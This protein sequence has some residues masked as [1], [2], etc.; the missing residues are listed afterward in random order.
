MKDLKNL[1]KYIKERNIRN[2]ANNTNGGAKSGDGEEKDMEKEKEKK[3]SG[4]C[5]LHR[6]DDLYSAKNAQEQVCNFF[7]FCPHFPSNMFHYFLADVLVYIFIHSINLHIH[8]F[9][10]LFITCI[11]MFNF[12][13]FSVLTILLFYFLG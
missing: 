13:Y 3:K 9:H 5:P 11:I 6:D 2:S 4:K 1:S 8:Y 12:V 10:S 7:L